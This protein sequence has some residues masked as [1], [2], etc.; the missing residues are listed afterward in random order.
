MGIRVNPGNWENGGPTIIDVPAL[1]DIP[2]L[3][4]S[5]FRA[6]AGGSLARWTMSGWVKR[7]AMHQQQIAANAQQ[8]KSDSQQ[9]Q[10]L[11]THIA[12]VS[13]SRTNL[14]FLAMAYAQATGDLAERYNDL[15]R[16]HGLKETP[17]TTEAVAQQ[18]ISQRVALGQH[19]T[20]QYA[21]KLGYRTENEPQV[22]QMHK[23]L[24]TNPAAITQWLGARRLHQAIA[25]DAEAERSTEGETARHPSGD[26]GSRTHD[27]LARWK[28][29]LLNGPSVRHPETEGAYTVADYLPKTS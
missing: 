7:A 21:A 16:R 27:P 2:V 9:H 20:M 19:G 29:A 26:I 11:N 12:S 3:G 18:V 6:R 23:D 8:R 1:S 24:A 13:A 25:V 4:N 10:A 5:A 28:Q 15:I 22:F 14:A 17:I